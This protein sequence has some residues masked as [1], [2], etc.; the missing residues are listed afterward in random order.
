M[1]SLRALPDK[2]L[3]TGYTTD[4]LHQKVTEKSPVPSASHFPL[5]TV[6]AILHILTYLRPFAHIHGRLLLRT[7]TPRQKYIELVNLS[8]LHH[9]HPSRIPAPNEPSAIRSPASVCFSSIPSSQTTSD[10]C[11][12]QPFFTYWPSICLFRAASGK[13][14]VTLLPLN[15]KPQLQR[16]M[17]LSHGMNV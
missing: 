6:E 16:Q 9:Q 3:D 2:L 7:A 14:A 4:E 17:Q 1:E 12:F 5:V 15:L 10:Y 8:H 11:S 13:R